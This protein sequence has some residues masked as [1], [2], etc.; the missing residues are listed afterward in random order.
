LR[1]YQ[2]VD[3][4]LT[5]CDSY[6]YV[7]ESLKRLRSRELRE[8]GDSFFWLTSCTRVRQNDQ[9][10]ELDG[11][12]R[13]ALSS[14]L[15]AC[16]ETFCWVYEQFGYPKWAGKVGPSQLNLSITPNQAQSWLELDGHRICSSLLNFFD[17]M[18]RR[19]TVHTAVLQFA[20]VVC[21][22]FVEAV[23]AHLEGNPH[24]LVLVKGV[25]NPDRMRYTD[26][27]AGI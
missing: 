15:N 12:K 21:Q 23:K 9:F 19:G 25:A 14:Y 3:D 20:N 2:Y 6:I 24:R 4:Y 10:P 27:F 11:P 5:G 17:R 16:L 18:H 22:V 1:P 13:S 8:H 26:L 7:T